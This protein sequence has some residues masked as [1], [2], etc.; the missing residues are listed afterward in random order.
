MKKNNHPGPPQANKKF[1]RGVGTFFIKKVPT[2]RRA[3]GGIIIL[4]ILLAIGVYMETIGRIVL[5]SPEATPFFED[6]RGNYI[7]EGWGSDSVKGY[8]ALEGNLPERVKRCFIA[9]EDKRFHRHGGVDFYAVG[10]AVVNNISG[11]PRHGASTIAM[12][13]A[14]MQNPG[15]RS[16]WNKFCEMV[17]AGLLI[18]KYGR[19]RVLRHYLRLVPQGN[20]IHGSAYA[21]RRYFRKPLCDLGWA[22]AALLAALPKAPGRMNLF[23]YAGFKRAAGRA[24]IVL[25]QLFLQELIGAEQYRVSVRHLAQLRPPGREHRPIHSFHAIMSMEESIKQSGL[26]AFQRPVRTS[27]DLE[28]QEYLDS[29]ATESLLYFRRQGAGNMALMVV[30]RKGGEIRGYLG[31]EFYYD[32]RNAGAID[33]ARTPR[34]SGSTL[35][36]FLYALGLA[37]NRF[38]AS[39]ILADL[40]FHIAHRS[41]QYA[42]FNYDGDF[43]GPL[44]FRKALANS[45]NVPAVQVLRRVGVNRAHRFFKRIGLERSRTGSGHYGLGLAVG[46]LYVTL[47]DLVRAYGIL[48]NDGRD[49]TLNWF[50]ESGRGDVSDK[51]GTWTGKSGLDFHNRVIPEDVARQVTQFLSDAPSRLPSFKRMSVLEYPFPVAVKTGTSQG[52]RDAW[53]VAY[54]RRYIVGAWIGH[55]NNDR[56]KEVNGLS[57]ARV[58]KRIMYHLHPEA[59][60]GINEEPFAQPRGFKPV[61]LCGYSGQLAT[62]LCEDVTLEYFKPGTEPVSSC[63]VHRRFAV[64]KRTGEAA[65]PG[66]APGFVELK[67]FTVL[68]PEYSA[69]AKGMGLEKPPLQIPSIPLASL[70]IRNPVNKS[71]VLLDPETPRRFQTL[72]LKAKVTPAVS[73]IIW[74][75]DGK[76]S[77]PV[78]YPYVYRWPL[79]PGR[80]TF[81]A[82]FPHA[83]VSSE[84]VTVSVSEY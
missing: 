55:A 58:V 68:P 44:L 45:R 59:K 73:H 42:V 47:V 39:D 13:V 82:R 36:P 71:K 10:R 28:L 4:V 79:E 72:S 57:A 33:Y 31:S 48:S 78:S 70:A 69:W 15:K 50:P 76:E 24:R 49:F 1:F 17:I 3:A 74:V 38:R 66:T 19:E 22:E 65:G 37:D 21:A 20:R 32:Q 84:V 60:R 46:G 6:W 54:S 40:P 63:G 23:S 75:I 67:T 8:W 16:Y 34:S 29:V 14:R 26:N 18:R 11:G 25:R 62:D 35:K 5:E 64:D 52:F 77:K 81:Q 53:A 12:Q 80:H 2:P 43:L 7:S 30:E 83:N 27:L 9:V 51:G 61:R 56:M 41:G